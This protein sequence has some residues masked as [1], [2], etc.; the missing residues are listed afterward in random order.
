MEGVVCIV[1]GNMTTTPPSGFPALIGETRKGSAQIA[2][3]ISHGHVD[4]LIA[5]RGVGRRRDRHF[6]CYRCSTGR[7][8]RRNSSARWDW[9]SHLSLTYSCV[10]LCAFPIIYPSFK[11]IIKEHRFSVDGSLVVLSLLRQGELCTTWISTTSISTVSAGLLESQLVLR[12]RLCVRRFGTVGQYMSGFPAVPACRGLS[13]LHKDCPF[14]FRS[15]SGPVTR[16]ELL[17]V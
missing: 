9:R 11:T 16:L 4:R 1:I 12:D 14:L 7:G 17:V 10:G 6:R 5:G 13:V 2:G 8:D 15:H 3:S